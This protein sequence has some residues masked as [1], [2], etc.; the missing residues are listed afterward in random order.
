MQTLA[1]SSAWQ[2][3]LHRRPMFMSIAVLAWSTKYAV[4]LAAVH[5]TGAEL[6]GVLTAVIAMGAALANLAVFR[7]QRVHVLVVV[8]LL[9]IWALVGLAGMG[10][11]VAH[12]V[13]PVAGHGP[14][15][16]RPR[17]VLA[18]LVFTVLASVGALALVLARR[19]AT[20]TSN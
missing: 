7:A 2:S 12:L 15:D 5:T 8:L 1:T 4:S 10:G 11:A 20:R 13:G 17:P 6:Y 9:G 3:F 14:L 19:M 16:P 18:P